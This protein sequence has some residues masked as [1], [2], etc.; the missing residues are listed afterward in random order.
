MIIFSAMVTGLMWYMFLNIRSREKE[1]EAGLLRV[2]PAF[3]KPD[4]IKTTDVSEVS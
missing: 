1:T 4:S 3:E 2:R